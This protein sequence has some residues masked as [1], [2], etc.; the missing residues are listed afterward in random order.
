[1]DVEGEEVAVGSQ[2]ETMRGFRTVPGVG[3]TLAST[4]PVKTGVSERVGDAGRE[5]IRRR[6]SGR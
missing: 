4:S 6:A 1:M 3:E 5:T 2:V